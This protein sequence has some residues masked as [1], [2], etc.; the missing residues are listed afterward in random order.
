MKRRSPG[1][2]GRSACA[3]RES[4]ATVASRRGAP[5]AAPLLAQLR[6]SA[7]RSFERRAGLEVVDTGGS[8]GSARSPAAREHAPAQEHGRPAAAQAALRPRACARRGLRGARRSAGHGERFRSRSA[9][10]PL[11]DVD[12]DHVRRAGDVHRGAGG[13]HDTVAGLDDPRVP[14]GVERGRPELLDVARTRGRAAASRPTR[15]P[16]AAASTGGASA[17]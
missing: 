8:R 12:L 5:R 9:V 15:A 16:S 2:R 13:D 17:R 11:G 6:T 10:L 4:A 3:S 14:R 7:A 1:R